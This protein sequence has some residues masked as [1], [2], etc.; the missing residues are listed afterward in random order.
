MSQTH[1]SRLL[2]RVLAGEEVVIGSYRDAGGAPRSHAGGGTDAPLAGRLAWSGPNRGRLRRA[3]RLAR[4][5]PPRRSS[6]TLLLNTHIVLWALAADDRLA[7]PLRELIVDGRN[8]TDT[9]SGRAVCPAIT[10]ILST[11][12]SWRRPPPGPDPGQLDRRLSAYG[13]DVLPA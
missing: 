13:V 6:V 9:P 2:D 7:S 1:L 12:C 5:R 4:G 3:P 11:G 8:D 10:T